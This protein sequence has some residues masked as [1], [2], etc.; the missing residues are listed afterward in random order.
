M[1]LNI[2]NLLII[3]FALLF[4]EEGYSF[5]KNKVQYEKLTWN[6]HSLPFIDS[7]FHQ[8]QDAL[9]FITAA[10]VLKDYEQ[11]SKYFN[12][13][14]KRKVPL[15][16]MGSP[17]LFE[18]TNVTQG[19]IPEGVGGFTE[20]MKNRI[21][22]PF[23]GDY[24]EYRHVM[25]HELV[26]AFQFG[27]I[28]E[29]AGQA[30]MRGGS[31][32][33]PLWF[34]EGLAEF[35][36]SG[37]DKSADMFMMDQVVYNE[38][39]PP[40]PALGGYMSYKGGQSFFYFLWSIGGDEKFMKMLN[41]FRLSKKA[42]I[43]IEDTYDETLEDLGKMWIQQLKQIYWPEIGHRLD[44]DFNSLPITDHIEQRAYVNIKP[45]ITANGEKIAFYSDIKDNPGIVLVD[46]T[47]KKIQHISQ[48]G[49]GSFFESFQPFRSGFTFSPDGQKIAFI[50]KASG[51][52]DIRI[53]DLTT[54]KVTRKISFRKLKA[55]SSLDWD[56]SGRN[57]LFTGLS[58]D[59]GDLY[60]YDLNK[61]S[62]VRLTNSIFYEKDARFSPSGE[63]IIFSST[64]TA[65]SLAN[66]PYNLS[67]QSDLYT[68]SIKDKKIRRIT[69]TP[70]NE[71]QAIFSPDGKHI[72]FISDEHGID[73]IYITKT[74]SPDSNICL[75]NYIGSCSY[76]DW[77]KESNEIV[78]TLFQKQ[79]WNI[80]KIP[81]PLSA[82]PDSLPKE[83]TWTKHTTKKNIDY[84]SPKRNKVKHRKKKK[85]TK[86]TIK[87]E[88]PEKNQ[89]TESET[90]NNSAISISEDIE[91]SD[92]GVSDSGVSDSGVSDSGVSD[93]GVSDSSVSDSSVSDSSVSDSSVSDS[94]V[95][96]SS[97]SDSSVSDSSVSDSSVSDSSVS[98]SSVSDSSVSDS[99]VSDSSVSDSSV[100]D[101]SVSDSSVSDSSV[102]DSSVS[103]SS[104]SDSSVS[105]SGVSTEKEHPLR[106]NA[107]TIDFNKDTLT[108]QKYKLKFKPDAMILGL[109][110]NSMYGYGGQGAISFSDLL[111]NHQMAIAANIQ[112][113]LKETGIYLSYFNT[114]F[115]TDFGGSIFLDRYYTY[116]DYDLDLLQHRT[117]IGFNGLL[118][119]PVS[120]FQRIDLSF[121]FKSISDNPQMIEGNEIIE[122]PS[123]KDSETKVFIPS[124]SHVYDNILWGLTGPARGVRAK[125][126]IL[127]QPPI[128][129]TEAAFF[130]LDTDLRHYLHIGKRF[131]WANRLAVGFSE[132]LGD[133]DVERK[134][135][136]GGNTFWLFYYLNL[137]SY[138]ENYDNSTYSS[139]VLPFRGWDYFDITGTRFAVLNTEFRFPFVKEVSL[140]WPLP[141]TIKYIN[142][143]LFADIGNA[144][145]PEEQ[146]DNLPLPEKIY[147]GV[148]MGMRINLGIFVLRYDAAWK[149]DWTTFINGTRHYWSL[150]AEF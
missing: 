145:E 68:L 137:D 97:V 124:V 91:I 123:R 15:I 86:E 12:Y 25:H 106:K 116:S 38:V 94:S 93:S 1:R 127:F 28:F 16:V 83:T 33:L 113:D 24:Q 90:T 64:D 65:N 72:A 102:S 150:G 78:F 45:K 139:H 147:G 35:L 54:G 76:P 87:E 110:F 48:F 138:Q 22:I 29:S 44:A 10:W 133:K 31:A 66:F 118:R 46:S 89:K 5:G 58:T 60:L 18:Q 61:D 117:V 74:D 126:T 21:V 79:A 119:F 7:Y 84:Y 42:I 88:I 47:G 34:A 6:Y 114:K 52:N 144:W 146:I 59:R 140:A 115:R 135:F 19:L 2:R 71:K 131:V 73:N 9:P 67:T 98:D 148:G 70:W 14:H 128:K 129:S 36:S 132:P 57:L 43:A 11:V 23:S 81:N 130:S 85:E 120:I 111:G 136:L 109:A 142:G 103:D 40:G 100:S 8:N 80:R 63:T 50:T 3:L 41:R 95:S 99:S 55:I 141:L 134:F 17:T 27:V 4:A 105:D 108:T 149:T 112:G 82:T 75:T 122:D 56:M 69:E 62:L 77:S 143:A 121:L 107:V 20:S 104:V 53:K 125:T 13:H 51:K 32:Q 101:S 92:S 37:W 26:H 30:L 49:N 39:A 96:D